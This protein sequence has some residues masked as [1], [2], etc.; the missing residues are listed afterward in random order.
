[1]QEAR[2]NARRQMPLDNR[3]V[4]GRQAYVGVLPGAQVSGDDWQRPSPKLVVLALLK[5][6]RRTIPGGVRVRSVR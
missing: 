6:Q 5:A 4:V 2:G 1:M 3:K